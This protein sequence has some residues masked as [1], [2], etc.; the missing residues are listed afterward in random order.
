MK[1]RRTVTVVAVAVIVLAVIVPLMI[2]AAFR[3]PAAPAASAEAEAKF[4]E[5]FGSTLSDE[6]VLLLDKGEYHR[7]DWIGYRVENRS[8]R[9]VWFADQSFGVR[10][11]A[12]DESAEQW[13]EVDLG[14]AV[15]EPMA[16]PVEPGPWDPTDYYALWINRIDLPEGGKI[17]LVITGYTD[18]RFPAPHETY[19]AYADVVVAD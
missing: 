9:T 19:V 12:Y 7:A 18:L 3:Q 5:M 16:K 2:L 8:D 14:F 4:R 1:A 17:R 6:L 13:V 11:L 10:G 15:S